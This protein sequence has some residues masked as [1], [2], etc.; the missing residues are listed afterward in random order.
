[1]GAI[2]TNPSEQIW[3]KHAIKAE[4]CRKGKSLSALARDHK[5]PESSIR[6]A[7]IKPTLEAELV[8]S[9]F[10]EKPLYELFPDR[11]TKDNKR[12]YPRYRKSECK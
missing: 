5:M 7:L 10:L 4:I 11:W 12:I 8:I 9:N 1:M 3:D 2:A 6:S